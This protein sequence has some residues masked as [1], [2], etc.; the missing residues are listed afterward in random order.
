MG[1]SIVVVTKLDD[2]VEAINTALRDVG[3][4]AHCIKVTKVSELENALAANSSELIVLFGSP[5]PTSLQPIVAARDATAPQ[6]PLIL[7]HDEVTEDIIAAAMNMG[8][9]DVVSQKN[10]Q[11][12][13]AVA[14]REL[15][16]YR[17]E[18]AL[19]KCNE[20]SESV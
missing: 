17:Q 5:D 3:H 7:V 18:N 8:A 4:A 20:F 1:I 6:I 12:L 13:Q 9:R 11:W 2:Q 14:S 10:I 19:K 16:A 15:R